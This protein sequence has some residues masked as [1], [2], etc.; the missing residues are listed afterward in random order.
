MHES[1]WS[2]MRVSSVIRSSSSGCHE[3]AR[4]A[5]SRA[6]GVRLVG[7]RRQRLA[8]LA[9]AQT[10]E[11]GGADEADP[12]QDVGVVAAVADVGALRSDQALASS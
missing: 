11:L 5:Q 7:Q 6:V 10:D 1:S 2:R 9:Q 12:A 3:R 4:R 8:D